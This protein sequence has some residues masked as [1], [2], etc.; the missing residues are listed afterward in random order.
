MYYYYYHPFYDYNNIV[1]SVGSYPYTSSRQNQR[2]R[3]TRIF[4][5]VFLRALPHAEQVLFQYLYIV[6]R[7]LE[8]FG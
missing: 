3:P 7:N 5:C 1:I 4:Y 8:D 6:I 2:M